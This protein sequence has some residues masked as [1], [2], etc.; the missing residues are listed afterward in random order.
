MSEEGCKPWSFPARTNTH[1]TSSPA[2]RAM[3]LWQV[4]LVCHS[5][6]LTCGQA[7]QS[8]CP[9]TT[10][11]LLGMDGQLPARAREQILRRL[12]HVNRC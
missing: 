10:G 8:E 5:L 6:K 1:L 12:D 11:L 3:K 9:S 4:A 7:D 2:L